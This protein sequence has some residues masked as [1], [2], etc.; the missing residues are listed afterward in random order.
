MLAAFGDVWRPGAVVTVEMSDLDRAAR[1]GSQA[2]LAEALR[3]SD[4]LLAALL[5]A[6][7]P[8]RDLVV[9]VAPVAP[10]DEAELTVFAM[11]GPGIAPGLARSPSTRRDGYVTL[12]DVA[13]TL[14][15][16]L[17]V[18]VP[19]AMTGTAITA[20]GGSPVDPSERARQ[21]ARSRFRERAV[22]PVSVAFLL[23][24]LVVYG[25][26]VLAFR[27][28]RSRPALHVG[29][30][31]L[32]V[33]PA[34]TFLSGPFRY[35]RLGVAGYATALVAAALAVALLV[36]VLLG[37]YVLVAP[38]A[39]VAAT[40][41]LLVVDAARQG[42]WQLDTP[43]GYS[44]ITAARFAGMGNLGFA[45]LT[46]TAIVL[47]AGL[48]PRWPGIGLAP[49]PRPERAPS[50]LLALAGALFLT[51]VV[52]DGLPSLGADLGGVLAM[53]PALAVCWFV[54]A[55]RRVS[56]QRVALLVIVAVVVVAGFAALDLRRAEADR[57]HVGRFAQRVLDGDAWMILE[58][59]VMAN[60]HVLTNPGVVLVTV[61]G[62]AAATLAWRRSAP[63]AEVRER[64]PGV[65]AALLGAGIGAVLGF[66]VNDSGIVVPGMMLAVL[67]PW[68]AH[69]A[70]ALVPATPPAD[71]RAS[72]GASR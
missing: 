12:P 51:S 55:G 69:L 49:E 61:L 4:A 41:V 52:V 17:G 65:R 14:L 30:L 45:L 33:F 54:L 60:V 37:R 10:G 58:R 48:W 36:H 71:V 9:V 21:D 22:V 64:V 26:T 70:F 40:W 5:A 8:G 25:A 27:R 59:K 72:L 34:L 20:S 67:V 7:D 53:V 68:F 18:P 66:G 38:L 11:A 32:L 39:V 24:Q 44:P 57:T 46:V 50:A 3:R 15:E 62:V 23:L 42:A 13:P 43:F 47:G 6:V 63:F 56:W 35:D 28:E 31:A 29:M 16:A 2:Q 19:E 1:T